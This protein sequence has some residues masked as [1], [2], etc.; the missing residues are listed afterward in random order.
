MGREREKKPK[1]ILKAEYQFDSFLSTSA[2]VL[3]GFF[4]SS[5]MYYCK[6]SFHYLFLYSPGGTA[7]AWHSSGYMSNWSCTNK[8]NIGSYLELEKLKM[9]LVGYIYIFFN[10]YKIDISWEIAL[11]LMLSFCTS[12]RNDVWLF[13]ASD[14]DLVSFASNKQRLKGSVIKT[15]S[16][17]SQHNLQ[18]KVCCFNGWCG[19]NTVWY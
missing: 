10:E 9:V 13:S 18:S 8:C 16:A 6:L 2:L 3:W 11:E 15:V 7:V 12:F 1:T 19:K 5:S 4:L 17:G 14:E